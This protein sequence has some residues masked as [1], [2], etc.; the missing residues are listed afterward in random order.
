MKHFF[1]DSIEE[2]ICERQAFSCIGKKK[3]FMLKK[4]TIPKRILY[5]RMKLP[6]GFP[7]AYSA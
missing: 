2:K 1:T 4:Y 5:I 6:L 7:V 3:L